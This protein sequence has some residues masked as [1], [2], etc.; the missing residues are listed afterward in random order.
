[1]TNYVIH[2]EQLII[3]IADA[4]RNKKGSNDGYSITEMVDAINSIDIAGSVPVDNKL[5]ASSTNP[6]QNKIVT[7]AITILNTKLTE[8]QNKITF[9]ST[10][11]YSGG[12]AQLSTGS[13]A[14]IYE[15]E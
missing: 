7:E 1:M 13:I 14:I 9:S 6:V 12:S 4:I 3:D 10:D 2:P 5:S 8:L 11:S 15:N